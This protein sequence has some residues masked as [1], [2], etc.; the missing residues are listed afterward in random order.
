MGA[1]IAVSEAA[2]NIVCSGGVPLGVTN[3]LNFGNPYDPEVYYQFVQAVKGMGEAC[4]KFDTP[5]TG[6]NVSFYNQNPDGPVYPTPTIGMVGLLEDIEQ[7][8]TLDYK[9]EG[10]V[11]YV[12]GKM[13][14]D[15]NCSEYLHNIHGVKYSPAPYFDLEEEF[16]L[17]QKVFQL[18]SKKLIMSA[19]DVSEGGLFVTLCESGFNREI[20]FSVITNNSCR[21]DAWLFGEGQSRVLVSVE[22]ERIKEFENALGDLPFEKIGVVTTGEVVIDGDFWGTIDWWKEEYETAIGNYLAK[23]TAGSALSAI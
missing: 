2:R 13:T 14:N 8:M 7:K 4:K 21:K 6:G 15:I 17:Q 22:L 16:K 1:M 18:I 20:G 9:N 19:H 10:D 3:C 23:E 11:L 5:V 12:L